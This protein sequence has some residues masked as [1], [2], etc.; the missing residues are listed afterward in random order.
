MDLAALSNLTDPVI[1]FFVLGL[2]AGTLRSNLEVPPAV[3]TFLSLYLLMSIGFKGGEELARTGVTATA[4]TV[5]ALAVLVAVTLPVIGYLALR[6]RVG[7]FDAVAIAAT[8]G[9]VSAVTF[10]AATQFVT[11]RGEEPGGYMT[12][13]LVMMETPA[14]LMAV[15]LAAWVRTQQRAARSVPAQTPALV[16]DGGPAAGGAADG[17]TGDDAPRGLR[18]VLR[19]A[20]T[21]GTFLLL[22][23][24]LVIGA[25]S[26]SS[27]SQTMAP[28]LHD[29]FKGLLAFFL[30][31]M[32]LVVARQLR[33][34]R[35]ISPYLVGFAVVMPLVG[36][37]LALVL[38]LAVG[39]SV[40]DLTLL[41]VLAASGSYIVVPA[42]AR[43]AIP[44]ALESRYLTMS[45][46][47]T[48]PLNV[49]VGIPTYHALAG[50]LA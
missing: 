21:E 35:G 50:M 44:E 34:V 46:G 3:V 19:G 2:A 43:Q 39:L 12:V 38:G 13:A 27:G 36:A 20:F 42:V 37:S 15:L 29:L 9:S 4:L 22:V 14:V 33:Q 47:I 41:M 16:G 11:S 45:L 23:G 31:Q 40:G 7:P 25:A 10:V 8:Y 30:L 49:V 1:L 48:F 18:G 32:G 6:H 17:P 24:S 28:L 26:G 5:T